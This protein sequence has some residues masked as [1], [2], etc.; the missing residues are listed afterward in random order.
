MATTDGRARGGAMTPDEMRQ[1]LARFSMSKGAGD[2][3]VL[4]IT[5]YSLPGLFGALRRAIIQPDA[6]DVFT[7][8]EMEAL[9]MYV[10]QWDGATVGEQ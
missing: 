4:D 5:P 2:V 8:T 3:P 6:S 1:V 10:S 7:D 9:R